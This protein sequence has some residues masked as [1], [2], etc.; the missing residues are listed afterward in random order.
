MEEDIRKQ[1]MLYLQQ[2]RFGKVGSP[3]RQRASSSSSA[4]GPRRSQRVVVVSL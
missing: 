4:S 3:Q 2:H 1:G